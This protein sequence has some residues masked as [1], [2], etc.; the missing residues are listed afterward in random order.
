MA[1]S[2][3][4][5]D[6]GLKL[7]NE[8]YLGL[9]SMGFSLMLSN[10][11]SRA[12]LPI[13]ASQLNPTGILVG[14]VTSSWFL[15]RAFMELPSGFIVSK[16]GK[17]KL[18]ISGFFLAMVGSLICAFSKNIYMLIG[19]VA[20]WGF[21]TGFF[22]MSSTLLL[23]G[24][25]RPKERSKAIGRL[26][27]AE[28]IGAFVGAPIGGFLATFVGLS[29]VFFFSSSMLFLVFVMTGFSSSLRKA[30]LETH[31]PSAF[32]FREVLRG[33]ESWALI[34]LSFSN[35]SRLLIVQGLMLTVFELYLRN[36]LNLG[37]EF[38]GLIMGVR[39]GGLIIGALVSEHLS[40]RVGTKRLLLGGLIVQ[41]VCIY[42]YTLT[43]GFGYVTVLAVLDG[44]SSGF[45]FVCLVVFFSDVIPSSLRNEGMG[46]FRTFQDVGGVIGPISFIVLYEFFDVHVPFLAAVVLLFVNVCLVLS[47]KKYCIE[48]QCSVVEERAL[49]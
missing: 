5:F 11:L 35:L 4:R 17:R 19:G 32:P 31:V 41:A 49:V 22:F 1:D 25:C 23:F 14:L 40:S 24:I 26:Y 9:L 36:F 7:Y 12:F 42:L 8:A 43:R 47:V 10:G 48:K 44:C 27:T 28:E 38:I 13:L 21:G 45:I 39:T 18:I 37:V 30:D 33:F 3:E 46:I 34:V 16:V 2:S 6:M 15:A 20:I 29:N